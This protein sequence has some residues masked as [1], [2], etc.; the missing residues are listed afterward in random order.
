MA[1]A[2]SSISVKTGSICFAGS[3]SK[4]APR[5]YSSIALNEQRLNGIIPRIDRARALPVLP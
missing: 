5:V 3:T 4:P 1:L 2:R